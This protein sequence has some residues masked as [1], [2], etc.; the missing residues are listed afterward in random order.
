MKELCGIYRVPS[1]NIIRSSKEDYGIQFHSTKLIE[2][3][4]MNF[5]KFTISTA[6]RQ[7]DTHGWSTRNLL[8]ESM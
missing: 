4:T 7:L 3:Y 2:L 1:F 8:A 5:K 6:Q